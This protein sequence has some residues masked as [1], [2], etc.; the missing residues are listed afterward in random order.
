ME[1]SFI[2]HLYLIYFLFY[3]SISSRYFCE[4]KNVKE[5]E[6]IIVNKNDD[7]TKE[8][9]DKIVG[10]LTQMTGVRPHY[11]RNNLHR[12]RIDTNREVHESTFDYPLMVNAYEEY[13]AL[14][15]K[16]CKEIQGPGV[17]IEIHGHSAQSYQTPFIL[18]GYN[19]KKKYFS[20]KTLTNSDNC[21]IKR[22]I[23][24]SQYSMDT[25]IRGDQSLGYFIAK[26]GYTRVIPSPGFPDPGEVRG[27]YRG[28]EN[29]RKYGPIKGGG[30]IDSVQIEIHKAYNK[31]TTKVAKAIARSIQEW[32]RLHYNGLPRQRC[33]RE[34][35]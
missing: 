25:L 21:S 8:I 20:N 28:G 19:I 34:D 18:I 16:A 23:S 11:S 17:F 12:S 35:S 22:L 29:I 5:C 7:K 31:D 27:Y 15:D 32:T 14:I 33:D 4:P 30:D 10:F 9:A 13:H 6:G 1:N 24:R 26:N 2:E 3:F